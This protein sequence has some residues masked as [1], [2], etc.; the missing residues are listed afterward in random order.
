[1]G[2]GG[3]LVR[4]RRAGK[5]APPEARGRRAGSPPHLDLPHLDLL[6][7]D[8]PHLDLLHLDLPHLEPAP[9]GFICRR[10]AWGGCGCLTWLWRRWP[11][12]RR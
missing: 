11:R 3:W 7:L 5:P 1:M 4:E 9:P 12:S 2:R 10:S 8:L 6:H